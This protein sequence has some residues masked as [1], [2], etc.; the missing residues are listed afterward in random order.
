VSVLSLTIVKYA[1]LG[2]AYAFVYASARRL[3]PTPRLAALATGSL[4]LVFP[5]SWTFHD[6]LTHSAA[7]LAAGAATLHALLRLGD[8]DGLGACLG[9]GVAAGLGLLSKYTYV[10]LAAALALAALTE[11][12][13]RRRLRDPR[14]LWTVGLA[15]LMVLPTLAWFWR[16]GGDLAQLYAD[17]V[18][19]ER[20]DTYLGEMVSG[21]Y[22]IARIALYSLGPLVLTLALVFP[23][24]VRA[25][26]RLAAGRGSRPA[27]ASGEPDDP[28][29]AGGRLL[30][31]F[32]VAVFLLLVLAALASQLAY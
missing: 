28:A 10:V 21:F 3:L 7:V 20:G 25:A 27:P 12:R 1:L 17:E 23:G 32:L 18:R 6:G 29:Q 30:G 19:I 22:Y 4:L 8:E 5:V 24:F 31:R 11:P 13:Y 9:L 2:V 14:I 16:H 15:A 26:S